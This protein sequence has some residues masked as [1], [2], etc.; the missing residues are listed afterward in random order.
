[1]S[2]DLRDQPWIGF[3]REVSID[4]LREKFGMRR[5]DPISVLVTGVSSLSIYAPLEVTVDAM[6][7][8][9]RAPLR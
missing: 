1:M 3:E 9:G 7:Y 5:R 8:R 2:G 4:E 6:P